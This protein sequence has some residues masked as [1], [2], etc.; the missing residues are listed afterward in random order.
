[1]SNE[2][3]INNLNYI[4]L[5]KISSNVSACQ[6]VERV[7]LYKHKTKDFYVLYRYLI[8]NMTMPIR[9]LVKFKELISAE[10]TQT[11]N[12]VNLYITTAFNDL[13]FSD[14]INICCG[15]LPY[16]LQVEKALYD[17]LL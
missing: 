6:L 14:K 12:T 1:M 4:Q 7:E 5:F 13:Y 11:G 3:F 15:N 16:V 8:N 17:N 2:P 10:V 9:T